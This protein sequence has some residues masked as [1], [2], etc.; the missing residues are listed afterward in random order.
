[1]SRAGMDKHDLETTTFD[2][3]RQIATMPQF[4][5]ALMNR[6]VNQCEDQMGLRAGMDAVFGLHHF[7]PR[8]QRGR[9]W[10][11]P[12]WFRRQ[13]DCGTA[14]SALAVAPE[15]PLR[16][17]CVDVHDGMRISNHGPLLGAPCSAGS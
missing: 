17:S 13:S 16:R 11:F 14:R 6:A 12:R 4:G 1:M 8:T 5:L 15:A 2:I 7:R 10:R 9:G 3:A